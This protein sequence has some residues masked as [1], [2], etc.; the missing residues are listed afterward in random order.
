MF[1]VGSEEEAKRLITM[2]CP[3][4]LK[5]EYVAPELAAAQTLENLYAFGERLRRLHDTHL[6]GK[7]IC[8]CTQL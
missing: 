3:T 1:S 2:A 7:A 4:N 5:G 6:A 8:T